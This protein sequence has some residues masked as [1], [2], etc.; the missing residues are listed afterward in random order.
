MGLLGK[1][2]AWKGSRYPGGQKLPSALG[3]CLEDGRQ[4]AGDAHLG[5]RTFR[6]RQKM[7]RNS[8]NHVS[9][10]W[11]RVEQVESSPPPKNIRHPTEFAR[12]LCPTVGREARRWNG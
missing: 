4:L 1:V 9:Q 5:R 7:P 12:E 2:G 8:S 10:V 3:E 11:S 6:M